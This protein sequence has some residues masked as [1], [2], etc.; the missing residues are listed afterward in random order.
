[1]SLSSFF[2]NSFNVSL[3][4]ANGCFNVSLYEDVRWCIVQFTGPKKFSRNRNNFF[5]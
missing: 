2:L 4:E 1:M 5:A 3:Y